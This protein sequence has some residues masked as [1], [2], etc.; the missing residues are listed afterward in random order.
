MVSLSCDRSTESTET[1]DAVS[2]SAACRARS[3]DAA[4]KTALSAG[5]VG[6]VA[7]CAGAA[8]AGAANAGATYAG[9]V[10][11]E[12]SAGAAGYAGLVACAAYA[13]L[14]VCALGVK[15]GA[16][17]V[18]MSGALRDDDG[19]S[20][21]AV[22]DPLRVRWVNICCQRRGVGCCCCDIGMAGAL[23][24]GDTERCGGG[25]GLN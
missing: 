8:Y 1:K 14:A 21:R 3:R 23:K 15:A 22:A 5:A 7:G 6:L 10:N 4:A 13:S 9:A 20:G 11:N 2:V 25:G 16:E 17:A 12:M 18:I 24:Q 19:G